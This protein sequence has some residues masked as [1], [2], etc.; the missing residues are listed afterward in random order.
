MK[1]HQRYFPLVDPETG[2][3]LPYF[4]TIANS[5]E[6]AYPEVV[7]AGNEGVIRARYADAAF[8]YRQDTGRKLDSFTPR[9]ATLTFHEKLGSMLDKVHRME[10]LAPQLAENLG[11]SAQDLTTV[12]GRRPQQVESG[13]QHGGGN[14]QLAGH[15]GRI[16]RLHSGETPAVA[17][18]IREHYLPRSAGDATPASLPGLALSLADKLDSIAGFFGAGLQPT[19]SADPLGLRRS[20]WAWSTTCWP[21]RPTS[22]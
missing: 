2:A 18:A 22:A 11:G 3:L 4:I 6:L 5:R 8:F 12:A 15:H 13:H 21:P 9:L 1:K 16:L 14:D 10:K 19:G 17:Q 20:A 7:K